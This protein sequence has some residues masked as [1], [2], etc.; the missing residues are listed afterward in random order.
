MAQ[1]DLENVTFLSE[2]VLTTNLKSPE[3]SLLPQQP[4]N[5][6]AARWRFPLVVL[7]LVMAVAAM[8]AIL[9][10]GHVLSVNDIPATQEKF[11][12][13]EYFQM[14]TSGTSLTPA[15][16]FCIGVS[17]VG[18]GAKVEL[19]NCDEHGTTKWKFVGEKLQLQAD[20]NGKPMCLDVTGHDFSNGKQLQIWECTPNDPDQHLKQEEWFWAKDGSCHEFKLFWKNRPTNGYF[21]IDVKDGKS[22]LGNPVQIWQNGGMGSTLAQL[23]KNYCN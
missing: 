22:F 21:Y 19:R 8:A 23:N 16:S 10:H 1:E 20:W 6:S 11:Q 18:N 7:G 9:N 14:Q 12:Q 17:W 3:V 5:A 4:Q 13:G 15:T 2:E